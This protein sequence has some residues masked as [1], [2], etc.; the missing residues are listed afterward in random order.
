MSTHKVDHASFTLDRH[1]E[2][3]VALLYQAFSDQ[4]AKSRWFG[5]GSEWHMESRKF[6]FRV[7]GHEHLSGKWKN[8]MVSTFDATYHDIVPEQR[9]VYA[10]KMHLDGKLISISLATVLFAVDGAGSKLTI[11]EQG[12]FVDGYEDKGSREQG[13]RGL[14]ERIADSLEDGSVRDL[15]TPKIKLKRE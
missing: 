1:Y 6:D 5:G 15:P 9:I 14:M 2:A 3:P 10:Y 13:T 4:K 12:A 8:G 7:G 11:T